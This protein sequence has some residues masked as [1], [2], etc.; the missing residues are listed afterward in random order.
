MTLKK[1]LIQY[2]GLLETFSFFGKIFIDWIKLFNNNFKALNCFKMWTLTRTIPHNTRLYKLVTGALK[3]TH[4][5]FFLAF[6]VT[7]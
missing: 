5:Y 6:L 4:T 1:R 3:I 2:H 7:N